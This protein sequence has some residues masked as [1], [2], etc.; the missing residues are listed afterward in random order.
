MSYT[1]ALRFKLDSCITGKA[2]FVTGNTGE[3]ERV[4]PAFKTTWKLS[5]E[6]LPFAG[7]KRGFTICRYYVL[8]MAKYLR[9]GYMV[10]HLGLRS[11]VLPTCNLGRYNS[12]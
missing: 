11:V 2:R 8:K 3:A 5:S 6:D 4:S 12:T 10:R 1:G 7:M 9:A